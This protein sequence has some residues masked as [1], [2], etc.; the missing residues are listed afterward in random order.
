VPKDAVKLV[1]RGVFFEACCVAKELGN[2]PVEITPG[3]A[4]FEKAAKELSGA[5]LKFQAW[6]KRIGAGEVAISTE[7]STEPAPDPVDKVV[8]KLDAQYVRVESRQD[9]SVNLWLEEVFG[10]VEGPTISAIV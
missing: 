2:I 1:A 3:L 8:G 9:K 10:R 7:V 6:R 4:L 5:G